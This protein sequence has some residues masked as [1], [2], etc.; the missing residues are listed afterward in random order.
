M[1]LNPAYLIMD[2]DCQNHPITAEV[3]TN[4]KL[5]MLSL[6]M[7]A[8]PT[9]LLVILVTNVLNIFISSVLCS[10]FIVFYTVVSFISVTKYNHCWWENIEKNQ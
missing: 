1:E 7:K 10:S 2:N 8:T 5:K 6:A 4:T 9:M 3:V